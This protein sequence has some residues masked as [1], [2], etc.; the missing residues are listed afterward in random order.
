AQTAEWTVDQYDQ[1][2]RHYLGK[3]DPGGLLGNMADSRK[4][5]NIL[6]RN[7]GNGTFTDVTAK[8]GL[9]G[10]GWSADVTV[11]DYDGDGRLDLL[12]TSMFGRSQLYRNNGDGTFTEVT[13][14]V[15]GKTP[16]GGMGARAF[17]FNN[18]GRLDLYIVD[19]H[20]D[21][22]MGASRDTERMLPFL[23]KNEMR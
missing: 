18:D 4:E 5:A 8:E 20:S 7:N 13:L 21:M 1:A 2:S 10:L 3:G 19:M 6:Y 23:K 16:W 11:F 22:W 17:D 9:Q 12:V 15:L 14:K